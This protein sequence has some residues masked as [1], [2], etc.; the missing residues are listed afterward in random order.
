MR[1]SRDGKKSTPIATL[2]VA[3]WRLA[4]LSDGKMILVQSTADGVAGYAY[5]LKVGGSL[6]PLTDGTL[7]LALSLQP[8]A[9][10]AMLY[11]SGF[12]LFARANTDTSIIALPI[13][14]VADKCVWAPGVAPIAYCAVPQASLGNEPLGAWFRGE[15]HSADTWWRVDVPAGQAELLYAP[16][17]GLRLDVE[18]PTIDKRGEYIAFMNAVDKSLWLLRIANEP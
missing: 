9:S 6:V 12:T 18:N 17:E 5:E 1:A 15:A 4:W 8:G 14:T 16:E 11:S 2:G 3:L 7:G 10:Q 13:R